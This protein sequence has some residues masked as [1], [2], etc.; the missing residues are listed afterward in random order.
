[1]IWDSFGADVNWSLHINL[2]IAIISSTLLH[3]SMNKP[4]LNPF[5]NVQKK[6]TRLSTHVYW[7]KLLSCLMGGG[8]AYWI[9]YLVYKPTTSDLKVISA[10]IMAVP[11]IHEGLLAKIAGNR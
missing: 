10:A 7:Q 4:L 2:A 3:L 11:L 9:V 1:M 5:F 8:I 6:M